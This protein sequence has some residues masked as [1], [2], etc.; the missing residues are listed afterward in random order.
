[1]MNLG[2]RRG[3]CG[4]HDRTLCAC[5][6]GRWS[7]GAGAVALLFLALPW[8]VLAQSEAVPDDLAK[9]EN[10]PPVVENGKLVAVPVPIS[11]PTVGTGLAAGVGY[12]FNLD[13]ESKA[14]MIGGAGVR[15]DNGTWGGGV[16][17]SLYLKENTWQV[18]VGAA[19]FDAKLKFYG[20]GGAAG[21]PDIALPINQTG[22]V[23]GFQ[24]LRK[25]YGPI[26]AGVQ[27]WYLKM[28]TSFDLGDVVPGAPE[29]PPAEADSSTAGVG[30][31]GTFDTRDI[32]MNPKGGTLVSLAASY[33]PEGL[34]SLRT[35][36]KYIFSYNR[37]VALADRQVL[38]IRVAGCATPGEPP[39]YALCLLG[40]PSDLRGYEVGQ[41]RDKA[42]L[43]AQAEW[44]WTFYKRFGLVAFAGTGQV[45]PALSDLRR[46]AWLPGFGGGVR[47][48]LTEE[49]RLNVGLD[50]AR[51]KDSDAVYFVVGE[52]F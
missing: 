14:S 13:P 24:V 7:A 18:K 32:P 50:Y 26:N 47:Y 23:A 35:Y 25:V 5:G 27:G 28:R 41:Y 17:T 40:K 6:R 22:W 42:M 4:R 33:A 34:G 3:S 10:L 31:V 8:P 43:T 39:F 51:G 45:A 30:L 19:Y 2:S 15:T 16:A 20:I 46:D 29:I 48:M 36:E 49:Y 9:M 44:R 37:Y 12:L 38:T 1:M 52:A 11:N 21:D